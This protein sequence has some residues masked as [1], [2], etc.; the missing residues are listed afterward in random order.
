MSGA[1][2]KQRQE[3]RG[4]P[5]VLKS[6]TRERETVAQAKLAREEV[7][8]RKGREHTIFSSDLFCWFKRLVQAVMRFAIRLVSLSGPEVSTEA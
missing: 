1:G 5:E 7:E 4:K 3:G 2:V 6:K 8:S